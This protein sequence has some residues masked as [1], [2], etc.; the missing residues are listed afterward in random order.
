MYFYRT[1]Q[2][3][4]IMVDYSDVISAMENA[5]LCGSGV[6]Y[7]DDGRLCIIRPEYKNFVIDFADG[8]MGLIG[9][10]YCEDW[11]TNVI[12]R[13]DHAG[14]YPLICEDIPW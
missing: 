7:D 12:Y 1:R 8:D 3:V 14:Y 9:S 4:I 11:N 10:G 6:I 5:T 13:F 2:K